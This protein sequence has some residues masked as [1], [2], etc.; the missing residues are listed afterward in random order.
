MEKYYDVDILLLNHEFEELTQMLENEIAG[1]WLM[2][3]AQKYG[4]LYSIEEK[5]KIY[6]K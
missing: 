3:N 6:G 2:N 4:C 5:E 1:D